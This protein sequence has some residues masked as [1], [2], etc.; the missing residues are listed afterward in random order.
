MDKVEFL[1]QEEKTLKMEHN[2]Y[3]N[4]RIYKI[5]DTV[6][7]YF[8][9]G[10]TCNP[11]T[12]RLS[13]HKY[14]SKRHPERSVYKYFNSIKWENVKIILITECYL[15][16]KEQ[17]LREEDNYIQMY[18][19]NPLCLNIKRAFVTKE[20]TKEHNKEYREQNK[21]RIKEHREQNKNRSKEYR[22]QQSVCLCGCA[23]TKGNYKRHTQ[24]KKHTNYINNLQEEAQTI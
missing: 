22:E 17:L 3:N 7:G 1:E 21:D 2:R 19:D 20:E 14:D 8:Y 5:V 15:D 4:G 13:K 18:N 10:S 6:N 12:K 11:L 9:I 16:N 23:I 24:T